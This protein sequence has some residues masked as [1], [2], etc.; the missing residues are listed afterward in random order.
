MQSPTMDYNGLQETPQAKATQRPHTV[1]AQ[2]WAQLGNTIPSE[3]TNVPANYQQPAFGAPG[4]LSTMPVSSSVVGYTSGFETARPTST[5]P[6]QSF[7]QVTSAAYDQAYPPERMSGND[8]QQATPPAWDP[9][10]IF[11]QWNNAFGNPPPA[12]HPSP[13][14]A[15]YPQASSTTALLP[16]PV[17]QIS[18]LSD[19]AAMTSGFFQSALSGAPQLPQQAMPS[20]HGYPTYPSVP[21]VT[22]DMWQDAFN[23]AYNSGHGQKRYRDDPADATGGY[24]AYGQKRRG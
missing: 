4:A 5:F 13:P 9:S 12:S 15:R 6:T 24:D 21:Q 16:T 2:E 8:Q 3:V 22:P 10:G 18:P 1:A 20:D 19:P 17:P 7:R 23:S 14:E 11:N